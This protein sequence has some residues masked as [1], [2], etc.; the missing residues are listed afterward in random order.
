MPERIILM[1]QRTL[2]KINRAEHYSS[3]HKK[4]CHMNEQLK[5]FAREELKSGLAQLP[6]GWQ[7]KFK[8]MYSHGKLGADI[9][10]VVDNM[11]ES[12]LDLAMSQVQNSLIKQRASAPKE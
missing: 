11:P 4:G 7:R 8:Q 9:N 6:E 12:K 10:S 3:A 1:A 2:A 5:S